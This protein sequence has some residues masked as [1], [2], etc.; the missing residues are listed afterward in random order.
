MKRPKS[1]VYAGRH[2][3]DGRKLQVPETDQH[4]QTLSPFERVESGD[5]AIE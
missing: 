3:K 2:S 4:N 5:E 1:T